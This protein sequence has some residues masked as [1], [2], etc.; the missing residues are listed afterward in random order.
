MS[1][2]PI[3]PWTRSQ[4]HVM[5]PAEAPAKLHVATRSG[6]FFWRHEATPMWYT[7][8][9]PQPA[10]EKF[11]F[12]VFSY[13]CCRCYCCCC[14]LLLSFFLFVLVAFFEVK[15][16]ICTLF[17]PFHFNVTF[18]EKVI[19]VPQEQR[20]HFVFRVG[21]SCI[22][23]WPC[24]P[25]HHAAEWLKAKG[26]PEK[27]CAWHIHEAKLEIKKGRKKQTGYEKWA[28]RGIYRHARFP[29]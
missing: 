4:V 11:I 25:R 15:F 27:C 1:D 2:L 23:S 22:L 12:F 18:Q 24:T 9:K 19:S 3:S 7:P 13:F 5:A 29:L 17:S 21:V 14:F 28:H 6:T 8:K 16:L 26:K 10:K 20:F